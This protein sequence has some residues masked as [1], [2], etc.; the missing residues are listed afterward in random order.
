MQKNIL[1]I[2]YTQS[3]QGKAIADSILKPLKEA[4]NINI[5]E[6]KISPKIPYP[7][8]WSS[9][10]FFD[11]M[12]ESVKG[13]GCELEDTK[14][15]TEKNY[16]LVLLAFPVWYLSPAIPAAAFMQ[17]G[18]GRAVLKNKN[19]ITVSGLR[20]MG[21]AAQEDMLKYIK[22]A[23]ARPVGNIALRDKENN[24]VSVLTI[25]R[26]LMKGKK[27]ASGRL[28]EA[29]V[30]QEDIE[31]AQ[32][33]GLTIK[34]AIV[35]NNYD[36][37]NKKLLEQGANELK[38]SVLNME[39]KAKKIFGLWANLIL[40]KG[41]AGDKKRIRRVRAFKY[42]LL[43]VIFVVSPVAGLIFNIQKAL[44]PKKAQKQLDYFRNI[45]NRD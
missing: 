20:N 39:L 5:D 30:K 34:Q 10:A 18:K 26:W 8:P 41:S 19:I 27:E 42:Y 6:Y 3:G 14:I 7:F 1:L 11:S 24:L 2:Y 21:A 23:D 12:P 28:P 44:F 22:A 25:I 36:E 4:P 15:D 37:L 17:S 40:K 43:T 16:D 45:Q 13:I 32:R 29:G 33:F 38:F 9:D 35:E 31:A